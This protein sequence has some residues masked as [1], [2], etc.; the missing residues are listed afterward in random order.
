MYV[1]GVSSKNARTST[2]SPLSREDS[3]ATLVGSPSPSPQPTLPAVLHDTDI[4][5]DSADDVSIH[6]RRPTRTR[7]QRYSE[8]LEDVDARARIR[9]RCPE[10]RQLPR[11]SVIDNPRP[12]APVA[13]QY[14]STCSKSPAGHDWRITA[15]GSVRRYLC[16]CGYEVREKKGNVYWEPVSVVVSAR[17]SWGA[18]TESDAP[19]EDAPLSPP[20]PRTRSQARG[21]R[22]SH[23]PSGG[24]CPLSAIQSA[25]EEESPAN[26]DGDV[27]S[28]VSMSD[29]VSAVEELSPMIVS[30][31]RLQPEA[32]RRSSAGTTNSDAPSSLAGIPYLR[33][34][35]ARPG[36][37]I[38]SP[39]GRLRQ[40]SS[41]RVSNSTAET[42]TPPPPTAQVVVETSP[43]ASIPE[44]GPE[45]WPLVSRNPKPDHPLVS[46]VPRCRAGLSH[47]WG[48]WGNAW[49]RRYTCKQCN[50]VAKERK[51]GVPEVWI[52]MH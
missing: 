11:V 42:R 49:A 7:R 21:M 50:F 30:S 52:P 9:N 31:P 44:V 32:P 6:K 23:P 36:S 38:S 5:D 10:V 20:G 25:A 3:Q 37:D 45:H 13:D 29:Y 26:V 28:D 34:L 27:D 19:E 1:G 22:S 51:H 33:R 41:R 16:L 43:A 12:T 46:A 8:P 40:V 24:A 2:A 48:L 17:R 47:V 15:N 4:E 39:I 14:M 35:P 18:S